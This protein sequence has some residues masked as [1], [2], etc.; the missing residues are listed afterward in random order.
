VRQHGAALGEYALVAAR[1]VGL[2]QT[3][4]TL[5]MAGGVLRHPSPLLKTALVEQVRAAV[6]EVRPVITPFEPVVGAV[7]L[8]LE[9]AGVRPDEA[10]LARL[11][12]SLPPAA[13]FATY[14]PMQPSTG[15]GVEENRVPEIGRCG[16]AS[17]ARHPAASNFDLGPY[18]RAA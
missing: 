12:A 17:C 2:E 13:L 1:Q 18:R 16:V 6:P 7:L 14:P 10:L 9:A 4:F 11:S 15:S 5:V 3:G 8:A